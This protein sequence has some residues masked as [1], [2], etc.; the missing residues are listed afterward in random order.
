[1]A[2]GSIFTYVRA[3]GTPPE[4]YAG[5]RNVVRGGDALRILAMLIMIAIAF[6]CTLGQGIGSRIS[7][8]V[9]LSIGAIIWLWMVM[10]RWKKTSVTIETPDGEQTF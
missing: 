8:G 2:T 7:F 10:V 4:W 6:F 5:N 1:M 3:I 9:Y